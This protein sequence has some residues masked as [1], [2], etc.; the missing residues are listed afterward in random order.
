MDRLAGRLIAHQG[1]HGARIEA[2]AQER[3]DGHVGHHVIAHALA[4]RVAEGVDLRRLVDRARPPP[5]GAGASST[6]PRARAVGRHEQ[7][8]PRLELVDVVEDRVRLGHDQ[9]A[10]EARQRIRGHAAGRE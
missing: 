6:P 7:I 10:K 4:Q 8:T 1:D 9:E 2:A 3:A 5:I